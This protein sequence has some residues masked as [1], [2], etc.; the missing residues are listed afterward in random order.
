MTALSQSLHS[1]AVQQFDQT[2]RYLTELFTGIPLRHGVKVAAFELT[3]SLARFLLTLNRRN[4]KISERIIKN[5]VADVKIGEFPMTSTAISISDQNALL[6]GQHRCT[7]VIESQQS[8]LVLIVWGLPEKSQQKEDRHY[9]RTLANHLVMIGAANSV[10]IVQAAGVIAQCQGNWATNRPSDADVAA[11]LTDFS[12][13]IMA[14]RGLIGG[15]THRAGFNRTGI[16][17][18]CSVYHHKL[19]D[20]VVEFVTGVTTGEGLG[21][22]DPRLRLRDRIMA[23][24]HASRTSGQRDDFQL[25]WTALEKFE[26]GITVGS[27]KGRAVS[28]ADVENFLSEGE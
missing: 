7:T 26:A 4:R 16:I 20:L 11:V 27:L 25:T 22:D 5:Y 6:N 23:S 17:S 12:D 3:P 1:Q 8:I 18:A 24:A 15:K 14:V 19:P 10:P 28:S 21:K 13:D 2:T 9:K